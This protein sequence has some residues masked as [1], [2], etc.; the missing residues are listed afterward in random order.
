MNPTEAAALLRGMIEIPSPSG[1]EERLSNW[2][3][4]E[5]KRLGF[6]SHVDGAGNAV[7]RRGGPDGPLILMLGHLDTVPDQIPVKQEGTLLYGRGAVDAKGPLATMICAAAELDAIDA[8]L[9]VVGAVEEEVSSSRGA[10][11]ILDRYD[12]AAVLIAEPSGWSNVV[13]GYKG[14]INMYY[15]VE[16]PPTHSAGPGEKATEVAVAFWNELVRHFATF[17]GSGGDGLFNRPTATIEGFDGNMERARLHLSCRTP[18]GFDFAAFDRFIQSIQG[19]ALLDIDERMP[20]VLVDRNEPTVRT[21]T[22]SIRAHGGRPKFKLKTGTSD[23]NTVTKKWHVPLAAYGPGDSSLDHTA[24]EHVDLE[25]YMKAIQVMRDALPL[26]S[27]EL[28]EL[29]AQKAPQPAAPAVDEGGVYTA[30]EEA[31]LAKRLEALG[32]ME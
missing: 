25:E 26:L 28:R 24:D 31:E 12:P 20:A 16:R 2:L 30:D 22:Q 32:Y 7:G 21:L 5:M 10:H 6:D 1:G 13:L 23:M 17:G 4:G 29:A 8:Q 11:Y 3:V 14:R 18:T 15:E 9:V 19:D 27:R